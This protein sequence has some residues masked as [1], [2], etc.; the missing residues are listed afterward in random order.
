VRRAL[1]I[2]VN[3]AVYTFILAPILVVIPVSFSETQYLVFPPRGF[4]L[5]W[6]A[7]FFAT[8]ELADSLW[9][10][11]HLAAWTTAICTVLGTMAALALVR[12]RYPGRE[13]LRTFLM[14]PIV[15]P[16]LVLGI[17]FLM[18]ISKTVLSGRFGGLLIAH[19]VVALPYVIRTVGAS[20]VGLDRAVEEAASSLGASPLVAFRTVTL[21]LLKPGI[22]A[23]AIFAFVTSF[24]ELVASLFL[25]GPRLTTL[26]VQ[27]YTYIEYT[28]DPTIAA[29]SVVLIGFTT[30]VVLVTERI[31]GFG[32]FV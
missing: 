32:R 12:A 5:R 19:V 3:V 29:I 2:L 9:T 13:A 26:P 30:A 24:D 23:G 6:Y 22:L 15:M 4:T 16:R 1:L 21:P 14:A 27:I 10:S 11:L 7:N 18:F 28:S 25:T 17:A 20:L 8:R 31:V